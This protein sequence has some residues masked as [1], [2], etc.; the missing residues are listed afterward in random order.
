MS[1]EWL[2]W[3]HS[4]AQVAGLGAVFLGAILALASCGQPVPFTGVPINQVVTLGHA[5]PAPAAPQNLIARALST[6]VVLQ[7]DGWTNTAQLELGFAAS[8]EIGNRV[9][10]EAEF[11]PEQQPLV[12][13]ANVIGQPG[14]PTL[15][16]PRMENGMRYHW[17]L[18]LRNVGGTASS[19]VQFP[20]AVGYQATPPPAPNVRPLPHDG[21][22]GTRQVTVAWDADGGPAGVAGFAYT[23]DQSPAA[24]LPVRTDTLSPRVE[25]TAPKDGDWYFHVRT[26]DTAGNVSAITTTALHVDTNLLEVQP[27]KLDHEGA[28]NPSLGPLS[29]ELKASKAA[30]LVLALLPENNDT[31][32]RTLRIDGK[33]EGSVQ[34]DG[35]DEQGQPVQPGKYRLRFVATDKTGR[36]AEAAAE[37][38]LQITNKRIVVYLDQERLVA[39][40]GDKPVFDTLVTTGGPELPTPTGTFHIIRK[41]SPFTFKSPWPKG[42][43]Y[44]Y[45]DAPTTWAMLFEGSGYFIHDAPWR[46]WFGP[47]SNAYNGRPGGDGTGTHGCVNVPYSVQAKLFP[48]TDA[49]TPVIVQR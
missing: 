15:T 47:G 19:W 25:L 4:R 32:V 35:K 30:Q 5:V 9:Q 10:I 14:Q 7:P 48:W 41:F 31:A 13:L 45:E 2:W 38:F 36:T 17:T 44:W 6:G 28:W 40:E 20:G 22:F 23:L 26:L 33:T 18:R 39:Y 8:N 24:A 46:S 21:W 37:D 42:S 11:Q 16:T 43:P 27:P 12:G 29:A 1:T 3:V 34:W 49:G